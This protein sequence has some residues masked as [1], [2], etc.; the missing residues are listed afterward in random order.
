MI[1]DE[2]GRSLWL[3]GAFRISADWSR[4]MCADEL[5]SFNGFRLSNVTSGS[6]HG[7]SDIR[8]GWNLVLTEG[9]PWME[10]VLGQQ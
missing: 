2:R 4:V 1:E 7:F 5:Y 9:T 8:N 10:F 3:G 6:F